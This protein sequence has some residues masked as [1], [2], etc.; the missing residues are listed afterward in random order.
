MVVVVVVDVVVVVAAVVV[1]VVVIVDVQSSNGS[2]LF[3]IITFY[4]I[5]PVSRLFC[6]L[7]FFSIDIKVYTFA[8]KVIAS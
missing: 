2:V 8:G 6:F 4:K 3:P 7:F 5:P 1:V